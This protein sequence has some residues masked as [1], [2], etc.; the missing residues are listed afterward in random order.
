[1]QLFYTILFLLLFSC[2]SN[3]V[4]GK[5]E[6][7]F[8]SEQEE[9]SLGKENYS[10][11]Q[12]ANGGPYVTDPYLQQ[13]V[14]KIGY[15]LAAVSD[16][17][18]LP[19]EFVV[20]NHPLANAWA[21]PGGKIAIYRGLLLELSNEAEL[22]AV[23]AHEIVH[24]AARH[25]AAA[26]ERS[27]LWQSGL[28]S[29]GQILQ[30][31]QYEDTILQVLGT[32]A[33][34]INLKYS[35][36]AELEADFYGMK[37]MSAAGYN[38]NAAITL[39]E[40]FLKLAEKEGK[41]GSGGLLATH[42]P[43]E[44]RL[45]TNEETARNLPPGGF[46][47]IKEYRSATEI[48]RKDARAYQYLDEGYEALG[49]NN[50]SRALDLSEKAIS[51]ERREAHFY[52]LKGKAEIKLDRLS[53]ALKSFTQA[54]E[55]NPHYFDFYLQRGL[56]Y[57]QMDQNDLAKED[58]EKS[59]ELLPSADSYYALGVINLEEGHQDLGWQQLQIASQADSPSG[60]SARAL[61]ARRD[62]TLSLEAYLLIQKKKDEQGYLVIQLLNRSSFSLHHIILEIQRREKN[63]LLERKRLRVTEQLQPHQAL[64]IK[65]SIPFSSSLEVIVISAE[66]A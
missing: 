22:A 65:T 59:N 60:N 32:G 39:Q 9:I 54:I 64:S 48:L 61:L 11:L 15:K 29:L 50:N 1:M 63:Q 23:L 55:Y 27:L 49:N 20:L 41:K 3:P 42:P 19:Y 56:L 10:Y 12:Q 36:N 28:G 17:P 35:R 57:R 51:M 6:L 14:A 4:T 7:Q 62:F 21:L 5:K 58:L 25:G 13:Y 53:N 26:I 45:T 47:G 34:L 43:S 38:P 44:E 31:H 16:R 2:A 66:K 24:S 8:L 46:I 52:N 18:N 33:N 40:K 37:Y 30:G